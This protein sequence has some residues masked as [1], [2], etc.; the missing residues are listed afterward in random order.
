MLEENLTYMININPDP[1]SERNN[2]HTHYL[3]FK[4][5]YKLYIVSRDRN[6]KKK[7]VFFNGIVNKI[8]SEE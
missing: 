8:Q 1:N 5:K 3:N 6:Q 2:H 7:M 4:A